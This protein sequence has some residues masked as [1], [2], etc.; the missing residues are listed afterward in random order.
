MKKIKILFFIL[1]Y[2]SVNLSSAQLKEIFEKGSIINNSDNEIKG[3]IK[4]DDFTY[5]S[6]K[7]C[8]KSTLEDKKYIIYD[9]SQIKSFQTERGEKFDLFTV[10]LNNNSTEAT[11]FAKKILDGETS[12]YKGLH[13][14]LVFYIIKK[15]N[16]NYI[17]QNDMFFSGQTEVKRYNFRGILN[18]VTENLPIKTNTEV[19][20]SENIFIDIITKYNLSKGSDSK[21]IKLK[22]KKTTKFLIV[23][24]GGGARGDE[25]EYFIQLINRIYYPRISKNS[26]LNIGINYYNYQFTESNIENKQSLITIPFQL[27]HNILNKNIR[28]YIFT[29]FNF[30]YL[31]RVD[32]QGNSQIESGLQNDFGFSFLLGGGLEVDIYKGLMLKSEYRHETFTH[33]ILFGIGYNFS[34]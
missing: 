8:F 30:S 31:T 4:N 32:N 21:E 28:P 11:L 5:K 26:S 20:F 3:Y 10:N 16:T 29:G 7:I 14:S 33:L 22:E 27:Q 18:L 25:S 13:K 9:T 19:K 12:L 1:T 23:N 34:K 6:T 24:I 2:L 15:N 17:L